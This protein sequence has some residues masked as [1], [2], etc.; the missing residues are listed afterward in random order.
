MQ[1]VGAGAVD[2][3]ELELH[4][5]SMNGQD[6]VRKSLGA[7]MKGNKKGFYGC[8]AKEKLE[9][10]SAKWNRVPDDKGHVKGS[11]T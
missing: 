8:T 1:E 3:E 4:M 7:Y 6:Q 9:K 5:L 10:T 11:G 2:L